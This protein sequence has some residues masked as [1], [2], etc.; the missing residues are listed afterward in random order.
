MN[1]ENHVYCSQIRKYMVEGGQANVDQLTR[2]NSMA[3][4]TK[5][6]IDLATGYGT[7]ED[8]GDNNLNL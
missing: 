1:Q 2:D 4:S 5:V 3:E 8:F 7:K 6:L